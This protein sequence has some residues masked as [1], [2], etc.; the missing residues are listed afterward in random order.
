MDRQQRAL[1]ERWFAQHEGHGEPSDA[2]DSTVVG[3]GWRW[4]RCPCGA[5]HLTTDAVL[6]ETRPE[7]IRGAPVGQD[8]G[9]LDVRDVPR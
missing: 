1:T 4:L 3:P 8:S 5:R 2:R 6:A 9:E 7:S